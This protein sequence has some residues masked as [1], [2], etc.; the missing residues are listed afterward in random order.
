MSQEF[1]SHTFG[2]SSSMGDSECSFCVSLIRCRGRRMRDGSLKL[3]SFYA[4]Q[5]SY[6]IHMKFPLR[7]NIYWY[8][9]NMLRGCNF[10]DVSLKE[11][12]ITCKAKQDFRL[13]SVLIKSLFVQLNFIF[14]H[15]MLQVSF[16]LHHKGSS[17]LLRNKYS[18]TYLLQNSQTDFD[19]S[20][21]E[22]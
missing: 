5:F 2:Y 16:N 11:F 7:V 8:Y 15:Y 19:V 13:R 18:G 9:L 6:S 20:G 21:R 3:H 17:L 4:L 10:R 14:L 1:L 12:P 22:K